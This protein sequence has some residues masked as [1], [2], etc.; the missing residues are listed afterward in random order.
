MKRLLLILVLGALCVVPLGADVTLTTT[1]T[2]E[3][4]MVAAAG[5]IAPKVVT[6]LKGNKSRTDV[7][8]GDQT[9]SMIVDLA[10]KQVIVLRGDDRTARVIEPAAAQAPATP[11]ALPTIDSTIKPTGQSKEIEGA[12]CDEYAVSIRMNMS[13]MASPDMP[14]QAAAMM[15]DLRMIMTGS[16]WVAKDAPGAAEYA[17]FQAAAGKMAVSALAGAAGKG[18][19]PGLPPGMDRL[20]TGFA[21]AP[22]I[23]YL[24]D[25]TMEMEGESQLVAVMK[26]MGAMKIVSRITSVSTE[27][28]A[29]SIFA[30]PDGYT[31]VKQ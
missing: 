27:T 26:Q 31:V 17:A 12:K 25:L 23:P 19:V 30:I 21:E 10:S 2:V 20:L 6:R 22:G 24:T 3:G 15:K 16:A 1:T 9:M 11:V 5:G 18:P 28:L 4:G 13:S 29:D 8:T 7:Q 14:P